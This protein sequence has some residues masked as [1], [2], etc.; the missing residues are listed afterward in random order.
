M[1]IF[2]LTEEAEEDVENYII[3]RFVTYTLLSNVIA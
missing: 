1:R 2:E 3:R